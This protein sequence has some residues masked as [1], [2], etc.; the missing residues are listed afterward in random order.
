[1]GAHDI[2]P[3]FKD[4][5]QGYAKLVIEQMI[6]AVKAEG[7]AEF[8]DVFCENG[9]F[10]ATVSEEILRAAKK[11]KLKIRLHADEF[12]DSNGAKLAAKLNAY[13]ADHLMAVSE[14]G[15]SAL[16][17]KD[18]IATI[19]PGTTVFLGKSTFAPA[20]QMIDADVKVAIGTD[21]NPGSCAFSSQPLMMNFAIANCKMTLEEAFR[22]VT[23]TAAES[24]RRKKFHGMVDEDAPA[25]LLVWRLGS[26][27]Q[28]P[29][30]NTD[31][32]EFIELYIKRGSVFDKKKIAKIG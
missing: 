23:S 19:L 26:P 14:K 25:D 2:P 4:D 7:L 3:E 6:P 8:C 32:A 31:S 10:D 29:Y 5:V 11:N 22:G 18:V 17:K 20:R 28:I 24:L 16:A 15:I 1:M 27:D 13:S 9:W 30:L 21:Y 12:L